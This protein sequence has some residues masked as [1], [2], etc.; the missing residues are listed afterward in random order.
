MKRNLVFELGVEE[1][2]A[3]YLPPALAQLEREITARLGELRLHADAIETF[4]TPRRLV[5]FARGLPPGQ[6]DRREDVLGP[7]WKAAFA[8]DGAPTKAAE[9][10]ARGRGL[11]VAD[12][13]KV[14][15]ERG[16][17]VGATVDIPGRPTIDLL[18][19]VLPAVTAALNFPKSMRWGAS[20]FR[21]PRPIRWIVA[22]LDGDIVPVEIEG[23]RS[24]RVTYGHRILAP[25]PFEIE[26]ASEYETALERGRVTLRASDRAAAI[27]RQLERAALEA[28]GRLVPDAELVEEVSYLV[29]APSVFLGSFDEEFLELPPP[30]ITTAMRDHQRY[31]A[32]HGPG[33]ELLPRFL[34]VANSAPE[35]VDQVMN[36]NRR[37]LRAR[38]DDA[39][40]YWNEDLKTPLE[41]KVPQLARVVWL[42]GFG[43]LEDKTKRIAALVRELVASADASVR[44]TALRAAHLSKADL[45]TEMIK[46]GKQFTSL[47]GVI[48]REYA[49]RSGEPEGVA[50]AIEEQYLPRFAGDEL[51]RSEAGAYVAIADRVDTLVGVWATGMKPTGSKDPFGL[52]R[53]AL[54]I[55]RIVLGLRRDVDVAELLRHSATQYGA[56]IADR[57]AV[58]NETAAFV[59]ERLAGYLADEEGFEADLVASVVP[60]A[61][62][63]PLDARERVRALAGL[64]ETGREDLEALAAGF[65]RAKNILK[66]ESADG[67]P[68]ERFLVE[69]AERVLFDAFRSVEGTVEGAQREHRYRD[70]F[71]ALASLRRPIDG[72]FDRVHVMAED[73]DV[74]RNRLRLLA[75]IV[76][77][78]QSLADLSRIALR[79]EATA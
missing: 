73:P 65:K 70:A 37:V 41:A 68:E 27:T 53:G 48:G 39:R 33:G 76:D 69:D 64:R 36:G 20:G 47:Q 43:S 7:P 8:P 29:E 15:T 60:V 58:V 5:L 57:D 14:D 6:S 21:F 42:E 63:R 28:G 78:V 49:R 66:K 4:G 67:A 34:C 44:D 75:R 50:Q 40:F 24:G 59:R 72:F 54:G 12:L 9:G 77:R 56:M 13:R 2:P 16:P 52:R 22:L 31:F 74:R 19:E 35:A 45:I 62:D 25:G 1:I 79:E 32:V 17:Y 30:V 46:G 26:G 11:A 51:P 61:G 3:S 10:F 38:L 18:A 55:V 23:V 71:E